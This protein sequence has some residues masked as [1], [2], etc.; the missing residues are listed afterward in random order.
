MSEHVCISVWMYFCVFV[1]LSVFVSVVYVSVF[2][3][4]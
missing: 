1:F 4:L 2:D 3:V